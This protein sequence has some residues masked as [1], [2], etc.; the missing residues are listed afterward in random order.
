MRI[1]VFAILAAIF[2]LVFMKSCTTSTSA[3]IP[4]STVSSPEAGA[5]AAGHATPVEY[6]TVSSFLQ[7]SL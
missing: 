3:A 2:V 4:L 5:Q 6:H 7:P 1:L